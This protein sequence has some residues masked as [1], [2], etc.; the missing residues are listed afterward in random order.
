MQRLWII[1]ALA[2]GASPV[3]AQ[4][5]TVRELTLDGARQVIT[6]AVHY[7]REK[8]APGAAIAVVDRGG[9]VLALERLDGTFPAGSDISVG[10]ARTAVRFQ[11][12][13]KVFEDLIRN[14]RTPMIA[15]SE[16]V[17]F[18]PLLGGVP[19]VVGGQIV[20]AIGVSGAASAA[21]DEEIALAGARAL[22]ETRSAMAPVS[23]FES[24]QV[25][26]AFAK[27]DVLVDGSNGRNYMVH[28]SRREAPGQVEIHEQDTDIIH[29]LSGTATF[30]TG[31][32]L[33]DGKATGPGEIRGATVMGGETR[34]LKPGD[35][36]V[37]PAGT[38]HWFKA[39]KG[40]L[41]YYVV[42]VR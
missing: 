32:T 8:Q 42:K 28:A 14:G 1:G 5:A 7:A 9:Y 33:T 4:V 18:T 20:G 6:A 11:R 38:A 29:V 35:V 26:A 13:T 19:I 10:K 12:E 40:P 27:G 25:T 16:I 41:T 17:G 39:V 21:Q 2:F 24:K 30:V 23:Y 37:V 15:L 36:V 34:E 31:G 22:G 3:A